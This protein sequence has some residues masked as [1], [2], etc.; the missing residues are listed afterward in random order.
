MNN[1]DVEKIYE[2]LDTIGEALEHLKHTE[3]EEL[4]KEVTLGRYEIVSMLEDML[5]CS[6]TETIE[7]EKMS[8]AD[9]LVTT[10]RI[11][12]DIMNPLQVQNTF[13]VEFVKLLNYIWNHSREELL[14]TMKETLS[15]WKSNSPAAYETFVNYFARFPLWGTIDPDKEDYNTLELRVDVLKQHSYDFLW[16]Y[17]RLEDYTSKRTLFAI[18]MNWTFLDMAHLSKIKSPFPD[19]YEPDIFPNNKDDVFVDVGAFVG[20]SIVQYTQVYGRSYKKIY[21]YEISEDSYMKL[22]EN[23]SS[24]HDVIVRRKGAGREKG[25][26]FIEDNVC[27]SANKLQSKGNEEQR[28]EIVP[29]DDD[30]EDTMTF[31][32]MDIEGAEQDALLGCERTIRQHHPKLAICTYHGYEDIWKI[33]FMIDCMYPEYKFYLRH[34]GGNLNPTEFVLLCKPD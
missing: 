2:V 13:D 30:V 18:L 34:Y 23:T 32:K 10:Y 15:G 31:L 24:L 9:W 28:V 17:K 22:C 25:E 21:A 16:L 6:L 27:S 4:H 20:D 1:N 29:L 26:M 7:V 12:E 33:P 5:H 19:Y 11:M 14:N 3:N 8:D